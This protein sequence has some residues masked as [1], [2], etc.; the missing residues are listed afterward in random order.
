MSLFLFFLVNS[1][2]SR[3]I[4]LLSIENNVNL[5]WIIGVILIISYTRQ[6]FGGKKNESRNSS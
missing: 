2:G 3:Q 4:L 6:E 1:I 5:L